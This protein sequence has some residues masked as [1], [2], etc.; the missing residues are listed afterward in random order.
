MKPGL[1]WMGQEAFGISLFDTKKC[2]G[3]VGFKVQKPDAC[4]SE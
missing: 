4:R 1:M 3:C 2:L